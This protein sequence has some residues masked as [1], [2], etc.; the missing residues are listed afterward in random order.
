[1]KALVKAKPE[2]GIWMEDIETPGVGHN[3]VL[4]KIK[5]TRLSVLTTATIP[6]LCTLQRTGHIPFGEKVLQTKV[7]P[8]KKTQKKKKKKSS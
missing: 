5:P 1:M 6:P 2:R 4:I 7:K 8:Q 3:D